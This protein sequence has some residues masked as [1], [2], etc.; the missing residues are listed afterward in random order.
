MEFEEQADRKLAYEFSQRL[1]KK[2]VLVIWLIRP[3]LPMIIPFVWA[4]P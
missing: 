4:L 2:G 3:N 1:L